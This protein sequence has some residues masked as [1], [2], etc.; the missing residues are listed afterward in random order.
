MKVLNKNVLV[1]QDPP[2]EM[3]GALFVPQGKEEYPNLGTV[4]D[5]GGLVETVKAGD[6]VVFQRRPGSAI[7][8]EARSSD[9]YYGILVLPEEYILAIVE[10][11]Y[12]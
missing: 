11:V 6:R 3:R 9:E 1:K 10:D 12:D 4:L 2:S 5:T 8:P 7:D